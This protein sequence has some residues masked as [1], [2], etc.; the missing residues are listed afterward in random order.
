MK[1]L[2]ILKYKGKELL[3]WYP[4]KRYMV[5]GEWLK[6]PFRGGQ[7]DSL[8]EIRQMNEK[9]AAWRKGDHAGL[10]DYRQYERDT[11][12][13]VVGEYRKDERYLNL[14]KGTQKLYGYHFPE[15]LR[16]FGDRPVNAVSRVA[17][18]AFYQSFA[19]TK[20]KAS[21]MAQVCRIIWAFARDLALVTENPFESLRVAKPKA[22]DAVWTHETFLAATQ[23]A[24]DLKIPSIALAIHL[25]MDTAQRPGDL[26]LLAWNRYDGQTIRLRQGKTGVW[27]EVPVMA[28]LRALLDKQPRN[29]PVMLVC[30]ATGKPYSKDMLC[31]RI[32]DVLTKAGIGGDVQFRDLRRTA[33]VRLAEHGCTVPEISAITGH[34]LKSVEQILE[35]YL[36][37][38]SQMAANA[39]AKLERLTKG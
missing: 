34:S 21:M 9:L 22:R 29:S 39:I 8:D 11:V 24:H 2:K 3:Y 7:F 14:G 30:E 20:R 37:R 38:N 36:P 17:A 35:V 16:V 13:W 25:G 15:I 27:V 31:R 5:R 32:R 1:Y 23:A 26:R 6:C 10:A 28:E 18:R 19:G 12:G 4:K 33:V